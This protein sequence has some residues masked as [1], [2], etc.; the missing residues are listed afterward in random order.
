ML[1]RLSVA[2]V[3]KTGLKATKCYLSQ[4]WLFPCPGLSSTEANE[5]WHE[6]CFR[7]RNSYS[8][9]DQFLQGPSFLCAYRRLGPDELLQCCDSKLRLVSSRYGWFFR[10]RLRCAST[11][12]VGEDPKSFRRDIHRSSDVDS[13]KKTGIVLTLVCVLPYGDACNGLTSSGGALINLRKLCLAFMY[14]R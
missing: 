5:S 1:D 7:R 13:W 12:S 10:P 3:S 14:Q 8:C 4:H 2:W 6:S 9:K 11:S